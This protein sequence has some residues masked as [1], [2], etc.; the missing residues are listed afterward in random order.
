MLGIS[1]SITATATN[2]VILDANTRDHTR[3]QVAV[4]DAQEAIQ[5]RLNTYMHSLRGT[6]GLI[7]CV[8]MSDLGSIEKYLDRL[9]VQRF[10]PGIQGIGLEV[11]VDASKREAE[12]RKLQQYYGAGFHI[13]PEFPRPEYYPVVSLY[14]LDHRNRHALGY[15]TSTEAVRHA[16]MAR[17]CDTGQIS[18]SGP[19][20]LVQEIDE[21]KQ[22]GFLIYLPL[23]N[24]SMPTTTVMERRAA[25]VGY[26]YAVFRMG[27]LVKGI[28]EGLATPQVSVCIYDG[29][30][31]NPNSLLNLK[32]SA[33]AEVAADYHPRFVTYRT[34]SLA[35]RQWSIRYANRPEF[36][37]GSSHWLGFYV[38][39]GGSLVSLV[40]F[41]LCARRG[42]PARSQKKTGATWRPRR[43][44]CGGASTTSVLR[45]RMQPLV[46]RLWSSTP[47]G[48]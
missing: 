12:E 38:F 7:K 11:R 30:R 28:F 6:A 45:L 14:P 31:S 17:A 2:Y 44:S 16:A 18:A 34:M 5:Q 13:W 25:L 4:D 22:R 33:G 23:Y 47:A 9:R 27:D 42:T 20:T 32:Q 19:V 41:L 36:E 35:G 29:P 26:V 43:R 8:G 3:F 46:R 21:Q 15:D 1:L 40:L 37:A 10:Y 24:Q 39:G 48:S